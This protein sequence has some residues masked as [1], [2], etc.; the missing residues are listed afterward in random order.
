MITAI[1]S[2]LV[3][4]TLCGPGG[5]KCTATHTDGTEAPVFLEYLEDNIFRLKV[6]PRKTGGLRIFIVHVRAQ[7]EYYKHVSDAT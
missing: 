2:F 5:I 3:N 7:N 1:L 6:F 4:S